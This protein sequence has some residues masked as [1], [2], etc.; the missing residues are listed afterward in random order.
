MKKYLLRFTIIHRDDKVD[1]I[2]TSKITLK[3]VLDEEKMS[4]NKFIEMHHFGDE[5]RI[6]TAI[7]LHVESY[8]IKEKKFIGNIAHCFQLDAHKSISGVY[9]VHLY[10]FGKDTELQM[11]FPEVL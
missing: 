7:T 2:L 4:G 3:V 11:E 8:E 1:K 9:F 5:E 10:A 6:C